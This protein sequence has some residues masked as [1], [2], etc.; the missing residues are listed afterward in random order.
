MAVT[1]TWI[2][3][4]FDA[5]KNRYIDAEE[6][7]DARDGWLANRINQE[8]F[9]AVINAYYDRTLLPEYGTAIPHAVMRSVTFVVPNG[10]ALKVGSIVV[11]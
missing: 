11:V 2:R 10:A 6:V 8:Q 9:G 1:L 7:D 4:N 3:D 5:N